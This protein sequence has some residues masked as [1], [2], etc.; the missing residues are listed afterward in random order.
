MAVGKNIIP[1]EGDMDEEEMKKVVIE[2]SLAL[3]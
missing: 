2:K 1:V 3:N